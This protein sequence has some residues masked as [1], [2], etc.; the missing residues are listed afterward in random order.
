MTENGIK[1]KLLD[2]D[3]KNVSFILALLKDRSYAFAGLPVFPNVENVKSMLVD[4]KILSMERQN[5]ED[6]GYF[7]IAVPC[8]IDELNEFGLYGILFDKNMVC[9]RPQTIAVSIRRLRDYLF[10]QKLTKIGILLPQSPE[11]IE[12]MTKI[13]RYGFKREA[14]WRSYFK[15]SAGFID[16][17]L[18]DNTADNRKT[19]ISDTAA[20]QSS[21]MP[22]WEK[23]GEALALI[24]WLGLTKKQGILLATVL[25]NPGKMHLELADVAGI[26]RAYVSELCWLLSE[27]GFLVQV[28]DERDC[29]MKHVYPVAEM[30]IKQANG[31]KNALP[32]KKLTAEEIQELKKIFAGRLEALGISFREPRMGKMKTAIE[33]LANRL[34]EIITVEVLAKDLRCSDQ[35]AR[36]AI[37]IL[38]KTGI[39]KANF[40]GIGGKATKVIRLDLVETIEAEAEKETVIPEKV[41]VILEKDIVVPAITETIIDPEKELE[42]EK[43]PEAAIEKENLEMPAKEIP[44]AEPMP[45]PEKISETE[46]E[47][48]AVIVEKAPAVPAKNISA[49]VKP[50]KPIVAA[51]KSAEP[52]PAGDI[53]DKAEIKK[54]EKIV[55]EKLKEFMGTVDAICLKHGFGRVQKSILIGLMNSPGNVL[56][57]DEIKRLKGLEKTSGSTLTSYLY[58]LQNNKTVKIEGS[59]IILKI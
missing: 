3:E 28:D 45:D 52:I 38:V 7:G 13:R 50:A 17:V 39:A 55:P 18:L 12:V 40:K 6:S 54:E 10:C 24:P 53:G 35:S 41:S 16:G 15:T 30:I 31:S 5:G 43:E 48:E 25:Q 22:D 57:T 36:D 29:R 27:K 2:S 37:N 42:T 59:V 23:A 26:D 1:I 19:I 32:Q 9:E 51:V 56:K 14:I 58:D 47:P 20:A 4:K 33:A 21:L 46:I 34:G 49:A 11:M 44:V 8:M